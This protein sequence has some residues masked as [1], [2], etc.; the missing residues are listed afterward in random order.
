MITYFFQEE[1]NQLA[2]ELTKIADTT[3]YNTQELLGGDFEE[4]IFHIG[5][6]EGQN[7]EMSIYDMAAHALEMARDVLVE[8]ETLD[9]IEEHASQESQM[10]H[11]MTGEYT[12]EGADGS[13]FDSAIGTL[14]ADVTFEVVEIND[15]AGDENYD[16]ALYEDGG[17]DVK[18][19]ARME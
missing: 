12:L 5:A 19:S 10:F 3:E 7:I 16:Y 18:Q 15:L 17:E 4:S 9:T 8:G 14:G 13:Y 11:D 1:V 6:N 2:Q